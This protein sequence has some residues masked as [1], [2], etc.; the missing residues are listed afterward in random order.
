MTAPAA[1]GPWG[2]S[3]RGLVAVCQK[4][5]DHRPEV[6]PLTG[7]VTTDPRTSAAS[8]ADHAAL[9]WGLRMVEAWGGELLVATAG[10]AAA[11]VVLR[12]ALA[13][14]AHHAVRIDLEAT[15]TSEEVAAGLAERLAG[16]DVVLCGDWSLDRGSGSVP[17]FLAAQLV[18]A[19]GLGCTVLALDP[20]RPGEVRAERRLDGG[21]RERLVLE[22]PAVVSVE[23]GGTR[24]RRAS[25]AAVLKAREAA[26]E[27]ASAPPL[28]PSR[29]PLRIGPYRPRPL[30]RP[31][32][33][34][35]LSARERILVLTGTPADRPPPQLLVLE[36]AAAADRILDQLRTWGYLP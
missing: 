22:S 17:A 2:R 4:W 18:A 6:D 1:P 8:A 14:G 30:P 33:S 9:E 21:R 31:A 35:E 26:V 32:P 16:A 5:V 24:L 15:A 25:L 23:G 19:S 7:A 3:G 13:A 36:P 28:A 20:D 29:P 12:E 34:A 10:P 11:E 27:V